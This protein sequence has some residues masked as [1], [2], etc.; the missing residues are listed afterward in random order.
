M[1]DYFWLFL[2]VLGFYIQLEYAISL[3]NTAFMYG[4][5]INVKTAL[6]M[7]QKAIDIFRSNGMTENANYNLAIGNQVM[8]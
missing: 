7:N 5:H 3:M 6:E 1:F 2:V 4:T 8:Y